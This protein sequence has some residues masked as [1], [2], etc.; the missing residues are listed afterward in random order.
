MSFLYNEGALNVLLF[1]NGISL[2]SCFSNNERL[3]DGFFRNLM[4][5][6]V[7]VVYSRNGISIYTA[8]L[9]INLSYARVGSVLEALNNSDVRADKRLLHLFGGLTCYA[10]ACGLSYFKGCDTACRLYCL[11]GSRNNYVI[12]RFT[13]DKHGR[14]LRPTNLLQILVEF[15]GI[16]YRAKSPRCIPTSFSAL[17]QENSDYKYDH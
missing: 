1:N 8:R 15:G 10:P 13:V 9:G 4:L 6:D 12:G 7:C 14:S 3:F 17:A 5:K 2:G 11:Y 16:I